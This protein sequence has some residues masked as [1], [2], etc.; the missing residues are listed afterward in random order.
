M[1]IGELLDILKGG[2]DASRMF[3]SYPVV[4]SLDTMAFVG[5]VSRK[6]LVRHRTKTRR[7]SV[8]ATTGYSF[9]NVCPIPYEV[10]PS[11][12]PLVLPRLHYIPLVRT[13]KRRFC[14]NRS[15]GFAF[16]ALFA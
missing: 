1:Q 15:E 6:D 2:E 7:A 9:V 5:T 10:I 12:G 8:L 16:P 14:L 4:T 13:N 11:Y 3:K